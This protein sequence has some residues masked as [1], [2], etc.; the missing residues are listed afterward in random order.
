MCSSCNGGIHS[1][2]LIF[3][4]LLGRYERSCLRIQPPEIGL[5]GSGL[6]LFLIPVMCLNFVHIRRA[7]LALLINQLFPFQER[8]RGYIIAM[9][10]TKEMGRIPQKHKL[11]KS[12]RLI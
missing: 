2:Q 10:K 3:L 6:F 8:V 12:L 9:F 1:R 4:K 7:I 5:P 11:N